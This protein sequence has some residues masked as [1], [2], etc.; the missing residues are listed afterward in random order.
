[1]F[2]GVKKETASPSSFDV[3]LGK[4]AEFTGSIK[5]E[6]SIRFDGTG[7]GDIVSQGDV[8]MGAGSTLV[9]NIE[10]H[11][12]EISGEVHGNIK[13]AGAFRIFESGILFGDISVSSFVIDE[14]GV[15]E[16]Q[17]HINTKGIKQ[18]L[19]TKQNHTSKPTLDSKPEPKKPETL[20]KFDKV[21]DKD[22]DRNKNNNNNNNNNSNNHQNNNAEKKTLA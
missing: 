9:G 20:E 22:K 17:C 18:V 1:M 6:G 19:P 21:E 13:A 10:A 11:N 3:I 15:F 16:G 2:K 14:G 4:T 5:S 8:L 7:T 12:V